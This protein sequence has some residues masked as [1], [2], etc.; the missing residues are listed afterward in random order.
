ML[1]GQINVFCPICGQVFRYNT[2][3]PFVELRY[4]HREFGII[5]S[6]ACFDAAELKYV[7]MILGKDEA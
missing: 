4:H 1:F 7:R 2:P 6:K 5:C 3:P